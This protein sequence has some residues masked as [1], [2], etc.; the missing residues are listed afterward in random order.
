MMDH[1]TFS[2]VFD[3]LK[4]IERDKLPLE[5]KLEMDERGDFPEDLIR[6]MLGPDIGLHLIFVPAEY[7]GLGA[8]ALQI[9]KISE[10]MAKI[11]M[12][13]ATS[14]LA[15]CLGMDPLRVGATEDQREK[16]IR[17]IA[18]EGLIVGYA[19]TEPEAGSNVQVLKTKAERVFD[20]KG[21]IKG[22]KIN[23][24]KQFITNGGV[25][26]LYTILA[27]TPEGPSFFIL[28]RGTRGLVPGKHEDKHGIRASNTA[29]IALEDV[30]VPAEN[31]V[32]CVE[33]IGLKQANRVF[34]YTRLMVATFGLAAGMSALEKVISYA[35]ERVQF[36]TTLAEKQGYTHK[37]LVA[38]AVR[39]E[40]ARAYIEEVAARIDSGEE[41]LQVEG[42][43]A[44][45]F[46]TE[47]GDAAANDGIQALGGYGYIREFE[48]E[49]I[50][51]DVKITTIFEGTSEIQQ[52]IIS[53]FRLRETVHTKGEFY[54]RMSRELSGLQAESGSPMLTQALEL[55]NEILLL[56]RK[57]RITKSQYSMFLLADMVTWA[58]VATA[59]CLKACS[60]QWE[61]T[62]SDEFMLAVARL[63][64]REA[65]EK[66]Y[67]NAL[68]I[69][70]GVHQIPEELSGKL[71]SLSMLKVF[72]G[73]LD[74]MDLVARDL[75]S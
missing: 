61:K 35:K 40:A 1:E 41:G 6:F 10:E 21:D 8:S 54:R 53:V 52:N 73:V 68:K 56:A 42:S 38:H 7:G 45:Y 16:Y 34:G 66:V 46:A 33:G 29:P 25:A 51:R 4:K 37:F 50:K 19:V 17:R 20:G 47:T 39:L 70:H 57:L 67:I 12:A 74:D 14:F 64:G 71:E 22:Y 55:L 44:K 2:I 62:R 9:A 48:V 3:T 60:E 75:I 27:D 13:I 24:Q 11:D 63:F 58:E 65:I 26:D 32:G 23:G 72:K 36:G 69:L 18:D 15:I 43:I 49:K 5:K 30:Y 28:E 31:L 59:M